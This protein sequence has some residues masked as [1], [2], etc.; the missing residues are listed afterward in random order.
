M[1]YVLGVLFSGLLV[2]S[3]MSAPVVDGSKDA[4]Y[5]SPLAIQTFDTQFGDILSDWDAGYGLISSGKLNIASFCSDL[6]D[7]Y[8][9][10]CKTFIKRRVAIQCF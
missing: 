8:R 2:T 9:A 5:S 4:E 1:R 10:R 6:D 7:L 3:S